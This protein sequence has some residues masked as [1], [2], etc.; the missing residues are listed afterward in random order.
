[1][2]TAVAVDGF[3]QTAAH[4]G[5]DAQEAAASAGVTEFDG[6][7]PPSDRSLR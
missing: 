6:A 5:F 3:E 2:R 1:M 7:P 4:F